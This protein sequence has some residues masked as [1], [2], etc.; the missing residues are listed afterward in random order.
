MAVE[1]KATPPL[2]HLG[3]TAH[4]CGFCNHENSEN[5]FFVGKRCYLYFCTRFLRGEWWPI[6][7]KFPHR[8]VYESQ[9]QSENWL[10][11]TSM[12]S[13]YTKPHLQ[14]WVQ[15]NLKMQKHTIPPTLFP[16]F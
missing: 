6:R 7:K 15:N 5:F 3:N 1:K 16:R 14:F 11:V 2:P 12:S 13:N 9:H 4:L 10:G 8:Y